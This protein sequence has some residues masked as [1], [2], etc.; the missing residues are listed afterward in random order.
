MIQSRYVRMTPYSAAAGGSFSSRESSRHGCLERVLGQVLRLDQA[1]Q[2][3]DLRL[4]LVALAEL[5]L[6]R[7][8]LLPEEELTLTLVDL[9][10]DLGLDLRTE[11]RHLE[12]AV[13]DQRNGVQSLLDV[14]RLE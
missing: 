11:L 2:L 10:R 8:Q 9:A 5:V 7:L 4:V 13:Q 3:F 6:D 1:A 12:L 14:D